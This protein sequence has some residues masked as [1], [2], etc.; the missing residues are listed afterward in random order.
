MSYGELLKSNARETAV[1]PNPLRR[2]LG[3]GPEKARCKTCS[4]LY[5][6]SFAK[7]YYKCDLRPNTGG[8]ATDHR[9]NWKACARYERDST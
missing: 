3:P 1:E 2:L 9:I 8:P 5:G 7:T 6:K 4:H